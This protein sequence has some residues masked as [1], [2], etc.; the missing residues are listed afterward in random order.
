MKILEYGN[1]ANEKIILIHGFQSPVRIW[2]KYIENYLNDF[3]IIVPV[4]PGHDPETKED[5]IS[6]SETAKELENYCIGLY[7]EKIYA[8]FGMSMGGVLAAHI[9]QNG[10]LK[11]RKII[12][13][14]SPLVVANGLVKRF[15]ASFYISVTH[16]SQRRD[17]KTL[18]QA[19]AICP[20]EYTEDFLK[21]LDNMSDTTIKN[22][23]NDIAGFRLSDNIDSDA[24]I[25]YFHGTKGNEML[26]KKTARYISA[27]Y[28]NAVIKCFRG[29]GHCENSLFHPE[30]MIHELENII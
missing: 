15:M 14:G 30:V 7:G 16:K 20:P 28:P 18:E 21:I 23:I 11:P 24:E 17:K 8:V 19:T 5:L 29:M 1:R 9:W 4:L 25:Y 2:E 3:H 27:N 6:M 26:A 10:R 22:C 13:D 12:F